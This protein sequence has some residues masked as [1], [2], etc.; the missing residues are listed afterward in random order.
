MKPG[1]AKRPPGRWRRLDFRHIS[2]RLSVLYAGLFALA[3]VVV[4]VTAQVMILGHAR[5][6]A[7]V[8][9]TASGTVFDR[10]WAL[11]ARSLGDSADVLA[12]DFGFRDAV[13][14]GDMPTIRSALVN[15]R[16]RA[17]V[18]HAF[19]VT[20]D[21][22]V[23]GAGAAGLRRTVGG[24]P[25]RL[26]PGARD[27]VIES[28][29]GVYRMVVSP[30]LA[31]M[32]IGWVVFAVRLDTGEMDALERLSAIPLTATMLRRDRGR[33]MAAAGGVDGGAIDRFVKGAGATGAPATM[34]LHGGWAFAL[35][36]PLAGT[37]DGA[38]ATLLLT[39]PLAR[40]LAPYRALQAGISLTGLLG[41]GLV[42]WGSRRL[43]KDIARPIVALD[44]A[45]RALE[46]GD[47]AEV[48]VTGSDE[49]GRLAES[50]NQMSAGIFEREDRIAHLAFHDTLTDLPNRVFFREQLDAALARAAKR[51]ETV[52]TLC[53]DLDGFKG[54]NDTLGH[55]VGDALLR[56][57]GDILNELAADGVVSR[58]GGDEFAII[59]A[60]H[61]DPDRPR[62][63][64]QAIVDRLRRPLIAD[65]HQIATGASIGIALG[66][67]DG[68]DADTILKNA[69]LALY[70]AKQDGRGTFRFFEAALDAAA[71]RRRQMELDLRGAL[72]LGQFSLDFQPIYDLKADRIGGF[73]S[74]L[75]WHHPER[76]RIPPAEFIPVAEDTGLIVAM[77]EWV[78]HEA[79]RQA[80]AWP[81]HLRVAVNVSP[82][83]FR[84]PGF[85]STIFQALARSGLAP[86][87]LEVEITESVFLEGADPTVA[88]LH[89]L[90]AL[91]IRIALDDFGTGYSSLSYLRSFPF[92]KLKIDRSFVIPI[93]LD[94]SAAAI[95]HA[96][97]DLAAALGMETTAE[98]VED[99]A[100]LAE[101][102][103]QGCGGIQGY[104]FSR[105]IPSAD[106][107]PLLAEQVERRVA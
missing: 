46:R 80:A 65:G 98:G 3:M 19:V 50:F 44:D 94:R 25:W 84:T 54:V 16:R 76:G 107:G 36:K 81:D 101:L 42:L 66:P 8:E 20:P 47:R 72:A 17:G 86:G 48:A 10:I 57:V 31:P 21:G 40:A 7:Q 13:A 105:P 18:A 78:I 95:V 1:A 58:L 38:E 62:A 15:L 30:I 53:L 2:T 88:L 91:G 92:D 26:A 9:L 77:G 103:R 71:R 69:D 89:R 6:S 45:A 75:R 106:L 11:R 64:A 14:S 63:L 93:A 5:S 35:A 96:I 49:I 87:R 99:E 33:W 97:V 51:G 55:P 82:L 59:L 100:Q 34:T 61:A 52:A 67:V 28:G 56:I 41:L 43:A 68:G 104:L 90:R 83:Q 24:L 79:C 73:E 70:G 23:I 32:E 74:L 29:S 27:A 102:K 60:G 39:Y 4:A 12:R 22:A 37:R 85:A